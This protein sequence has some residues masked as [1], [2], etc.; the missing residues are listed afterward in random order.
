MNTVPAIRISPPR[1]IADIPIGTNHQ[2]ASNILHEAF[3]ELNISPRG[4]RAEV[5]LTILME[6]VK[7]GSQ[8]GVAL[9]GSASM[10]EP[11]GRGY[12]YDASFTEAVADELKA[13]GLAQDILRDGQNLT[14]Y[15]TSGWEE[16]IK[17]KCV[18][19]TDNVV[20]PIARDVVPHLAE[21]I[22]ADGGTTV[23]YWACGEN[24]DRIEEAGDLTAAAAKEASYTGPQDWGLQTH[25]LPAM[26]YFVERF[27]DAK[28]GFYVFVTDGRI[29][30]LEA[31]KQYTAELSR[32]IGAKTAPP[33]KCVLI[34]VGSNVDE[35]QM[36]QLDDLPEEMDLPVDIWD[37]KIAAEMR[38]LRDIFAEVV[39]ENAIV[40]PTGRV[41]DGAGKVAANF[42]DGLP[43]LIRFSLPP[44]A[45]E[46]ILEVGPNRIVQKL[47]A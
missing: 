33:V 13:R 36:I 32:K 47:F 40:S 18:L 14:Q 39:D 20:E 26:K 44:D 1:S 6:P 35:A 34:G 37:H 28:W 21:K 24:G 41:L 11:F 31:V 9:D 30:D 45:T 22:D 27:N 12:R 43:S 5:V 2:V 29:D 23:I 7:E 25:L 38:N 15:S 17:R 8:T 3:G 10:Q 16:L 4:D 19:Q 42:A 46:F